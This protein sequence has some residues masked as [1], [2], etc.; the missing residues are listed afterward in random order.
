M[1]NHEFLPSIR[2]S[3]TITWPRCNTPQFPRDGGCIRCHGALGLEYVSFRI[4]TLLDCRSEE[5]KKQ[6]APSIG[7]LLRRLRRQRGICQPHLAMQAGGCI[8]RIS[9]SKAECGHM[10]L[11]LHKFLPLA[12]ALANRCDSPLRGCRRR[13]A[14]QSINPR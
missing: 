1:P 5:D 11:P 2:E 6:L 12:K 8:T 4:G 14:R 10:L 3:E 13:T 9:L 7:N